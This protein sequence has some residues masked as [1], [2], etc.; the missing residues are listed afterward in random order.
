[1]LLYTTTSWIGIVVIGLMWINVAN[2]FLLVPIS[3]FA[4]IL[5]FPSTLIEY[6]D[7]GI[8][9]YYTAWTIGG[10]GLLATYLFRFRNK[11]SRSTIDY[12]KLSAVIVYCLYLFPVGLV[13]D[14]HYGEVWIAVT[15]GYAC[16]VYLYDRLILTSQQVNRKYIAALV[17]QSALILLMLVYALVQ[18]TQAIKNEELAIRAEAEA[19]NAKNHA[20]AVEA[21]FKKELE[22]CMTRK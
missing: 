9:V 2:R 14:Y 15:I 16:A 1:M 21:A 18:R 11:S 5:L 10:I 20:V 3:I 4:I 7:Q 22:T 12:F 6:A 19:I 13:A 8:E 17:M